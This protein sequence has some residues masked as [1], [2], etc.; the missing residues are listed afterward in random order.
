MTRAATPSTL[1]T[2]FAAAAAL[3]FG[4]ETFYLSNLLMNDR[5]AVRISDIADQLPPDDPRKDLFNNAANEYWERM[6][7]FGWWYLG[8]LLIVA[9]NRMNWGRLP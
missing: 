2:A 6:R 1:S 5:K 7:D 4:L 9:D 8:G 3:A